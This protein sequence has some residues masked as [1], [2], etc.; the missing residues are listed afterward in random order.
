VTKLLDGTAKQYDIEKV[1]KSLWR[2]FII[3][4]QAAKK[5]ND[6]K[7][8]EM[9]KSMDKRKLLFKFPRGAYWSEHL[10]APGD[11]S[12]LSGVISPQTYY[13]LLDNGI[14]NER[15]WRVDATLWREA[16]KENLKYYQEVRYKQLL[17][18]QEQKKN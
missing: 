9:K 2:Y 5:L 12:G 6:A 11:T 4:V 1:D 3:A 8:K 13:R 7:K 17:D 14:L 16:K 18:E 10:V 15:E